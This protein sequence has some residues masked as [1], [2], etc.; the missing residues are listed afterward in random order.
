M[1]CCCAGNLGIGTLILYQKDLNSKSFGNNLSAANLAAM[2]Y[3]EP[4]ATA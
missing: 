1:G 4:C 3:E 2:D